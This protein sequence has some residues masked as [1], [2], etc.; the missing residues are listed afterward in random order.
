[1]EQKSQIEQDIGEEAD[2]VDAAKASRIKISTE[3]D[4]LFSD[5]Q[6]NNNFNWLLTKTVLFQKVFTKYIKN[7]KNN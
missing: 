1:M 5:S 3:V 4:D 7:Y 6:L 2:W